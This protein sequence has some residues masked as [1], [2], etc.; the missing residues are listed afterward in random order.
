MSIIDKD[1]GLA[2]ILKGLS[3]LEGS[4]F[5]AGLMPPT[6]QDVILR[7]AANEF[8]TAT[9]PARPFMRSSVDANPQKVT[10]ILTTMVVKASTDGKSAG[11]LTGAAL[12][13]EELIKKQIA[14]SPAWA[15]ELAPSTVAAKGFSH[16]LIDTS[17]MHD[18]ISSQVKAG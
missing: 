5:K 8:G 14:D 3:Q 12:E 7:G 17:E 16:P 13:F 18:S 2:D 1:M 4:S 10:E 11:A 9:M 15:A 6:S